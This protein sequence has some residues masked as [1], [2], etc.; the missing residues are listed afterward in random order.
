MIQN[1]I[2]SYFQT[3]FEIYKSLNIPNIYWHLNINP[4]DFYKGYSW[5]NKNG[6]LSLFYYE[7]VI[8]FNIDAVYPGED[9]TFFLVK[10]FS[11]HSWV[12]VENS[13]KSKV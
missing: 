7:Q 11:M 10:K 8:G 12:I 1:K 3:K 4:S 13:K 6:F 2:E 9:V 5:I